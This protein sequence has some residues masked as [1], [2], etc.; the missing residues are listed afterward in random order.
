MAVGGIL[1]IGSALFAVELVYDTESETLGQWRTVT[2]PEAISSNRWMRTAAALSG[3]WLRTGGNVT[4]WTALHDSQGDRLSAGCTYYL[5]ASEVSGS[6]WTMAL[7]D[8]DHHLPAKGTGPSAITASDIIAD[9][10]GKLQIQASGADQGSAWLPATTGPFSL[11]LRV[12]DQDGTGQGPIP[13]FAIDR[14]ECQ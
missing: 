3:T 7:Y 9:T 6:F 5:S 4:E 13:E 8:N 10:R 1:G 14:G 12:Y 2:D 11:T